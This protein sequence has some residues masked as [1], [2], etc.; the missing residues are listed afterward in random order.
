[1]GLKAMLEATLLTD[2]ERA[3]AVGLCADLSGTSRSVAIVI[4]RGQTEVGH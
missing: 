4:G 3:T 2:D 1:L